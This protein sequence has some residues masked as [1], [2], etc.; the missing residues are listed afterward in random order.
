MVSTMG[1]PRLSITGVVGGEVGLL[2]APVSESSS[3]GES[4]DSSALSSV[5]TGGVA[6]GSGGDGGLARDEGDDELAQ[7]SSNKAIASGQ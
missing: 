3:Q 1:E 4:S 5:A 2:L 7:S 6:V